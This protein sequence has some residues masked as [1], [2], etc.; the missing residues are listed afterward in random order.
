[1]G[2]HNPHQEVPH[3][4]ANKTTHKFWIDKHKKETDKF[5]KRLS[6]QPAPGTHTPIP[7][8]YS[9]FARIMTADSA[10]K[11]RG[12]TKSEGKGRVFHG[13]GSDAK[14]EYTRPSKKKIVE[15]RPAPCDHEIMLE[16][17]G[18]NME[19]RGKNW[20][21]ARSVGRSRSVYH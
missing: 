4:R 1:M 6:V 13:F 10:M 3:I 15:K 16:W 17:K 11:K 2:S 8:G 9:T 14:F 20:I 7:L 19:M 21:R 5:K 18:K 12:D